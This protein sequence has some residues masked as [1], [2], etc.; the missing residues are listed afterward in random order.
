[1]DPP[2]LP[3]A[4]EAAEQAAPH[5]AL[6]EGLKRHDLGGKAARD[7][8]AAHPADYI[9]QKIDYLD[10]LL[11]TGERPQ[12]PAGWLRTAIEED[13][14][15]PA[16]YLP[17]AERLREKQG[18]EQRQRQQSDERAARDRQEEQE[19]AARKAERE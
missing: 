3:P 19:R 18:A 13:Y 2:T 8:I 16:G 9:E 1:A 14:G 11:E 4:A 6:L 7:L 12:R 15:P 17:R 10:F 5:A